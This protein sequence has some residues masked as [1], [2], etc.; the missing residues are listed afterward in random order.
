MLLTSGSC[1]EL[2]VLVLVVQAV[3]SLP[4]FFLRKKKIILALVRTQSEQN[5]REQRKWREGM[6]EMAA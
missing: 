1:R 5:K 3:F 6:Q 4:I 2:N